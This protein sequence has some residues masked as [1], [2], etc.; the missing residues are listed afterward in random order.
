MAGDRAHDL[1]ITGELVPTKV[2]VAADE[3]SALTT[4]STCSGNDVLTRCER[5]TPACRTV[6]VCSTEPTLRN[7]TTTSVPACTSMTF[8]I[9]C[10]VG[11]DDRGSRRD[12]G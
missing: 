10:E 8:L 6:H 7:S 2:S 5:Q 9:V 4:A 12:T 11:G 1:V 3:A